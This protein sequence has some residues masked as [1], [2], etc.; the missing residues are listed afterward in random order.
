MHLVA[1]RESLA[2][3]TPTSSTIDLIQY[4]PFNGSLEFTTPAGRSGWVPA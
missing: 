1:P 3:E 2:L 4:R